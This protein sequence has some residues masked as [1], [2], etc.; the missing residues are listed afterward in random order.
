MPVEG[1]SYEARHHGGRS[2]DADIDYQ[3]LFASRAAMPT[4]RPKGAPTDGFS[5]TSE[6]V[7][8]SGLPTHTATR[9]GG[10]R[11]TPEGRF[12]VAVESPILSG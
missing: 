8:P 12:N 3:R 6:G 9:A 5:V 1:A 7:L 2:H 4:R 11:A 10:L